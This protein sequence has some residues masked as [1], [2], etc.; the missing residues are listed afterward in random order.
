MEMALANI[1]EPSHF[2]KMA[3]PRNL[4]N[5]AYCFAQ[6]CLKP[7]KFFLLCSIDQR[8]YCSMVSSSFFSFLCSIRCRHLLLFFCQD[9]LF[10]GLHSHI[11]LIDNAIEKETY[12]ENEYF[13]W[14]MNRDFNR[15][16]ISKWDGLS[17]SIAFKFGHSFVLSFAKT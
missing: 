12:R 4:W 5:Y 14:Y 1:D 17:V 10:S 11:I 7:L 6:N 13:H 15:P 3:A 9:Y 2:N 8:S 16:H